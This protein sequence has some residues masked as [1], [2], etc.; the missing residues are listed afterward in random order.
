MNYSHVFYLR[1][2]ALKDIYNRYEGE[3][4]KL[5]EHANLIKSDTI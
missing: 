4:N 5:S 1:D 2:Q 3:K